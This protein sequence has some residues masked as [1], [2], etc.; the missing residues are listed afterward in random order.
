M[1]LKL[2]GQIAFTAMVNTTP[3]GPQA[4]FRF[5]V[6]IVDADGSNLK[7]IDLVTEND[8]PATSALDPEWSIDGSLEY[9]ISRYAPDEKSYDPTRYRV[10]FP[11]GTQTQT[12]GRA[13]FDPLNFP[14]NSP[15]GK[16]A[17]LLWDYADNNAGFALAKPDGSDENYYAEH[18]FHVHGASWLPDSS[19]IL[20]EASSDESDDFDRKSLY[21]FEMSTQKTV[22]LLNQPSVD[23]VR[24]WSPD[25]QFLVSGGAAKE[26][27]CEGFYLLS[28]D[29][30]F[31]KHLADLVDEFGVLRLSQ[32][33]WSSDGRYFAISTALSEES[34]DY[35]LLLFDREGERLS[36]LS[37]PGEHFARIDDIALNL[38]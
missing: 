32:P 1:D 23:G 9:T 4:T 34:Y 16:Y 15:D 5:R 3:G 30:T 11:D 10:S 29:G 26:R 24:C 22:H 2:D 36:T 14:W 8:H 38:T 20:L 28:R 31:S 27:Y 12:E 33:T 7:R 18:L 6:F 35:S 37:W 19:A 25:L 13:Q 17:F 21:I